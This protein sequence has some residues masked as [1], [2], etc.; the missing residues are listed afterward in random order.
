LN[1]RLTQPDFFLDEML[2]DLQFNPALTFPFSLDP[3]NRIPYYHQYSLNI[4]HQLTSDLLLEIGYAGS[5]GHKLGQRLNLNQGRV[6]P[7]GTVP[8][9]QRVRYPQ[10]SAILWTYN[11]GNSNY[12]EGTLR[13]EKRFSQGLSLLANYTFSKSIDSPYGRIRREHFQSERRP[14]GPSTFDATHRFVASYIYDLPFGFRRP[15]LSGS[16]G[17]VKHLVSGWQV[18]G[19]TTFM[20]GQPRNIGFIGR[21]PVVGPFSNVRA[22]RVGPGNC[23]QC[24]ENI[25]KNP[26]PGPYFRTEDFKLPADFTFGNAGRNILRAPGIN[27]WDLS[28]FKNNYI[29]E[30]VNVQFRAEFFNAFNHAQFTSFNATVGSPTYGRVTGAREGRDIQLALRV[31]F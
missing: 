21:A 2:P 8:L 11:G 19:I 27:N 16:T 18:N 4:Q 26:V 12:N 28:L 20:S 1:S 17:F 25:R 7:T 9:S 22:D 6:D 14:R 30:N 10:F 3:N 29:G 13:L 23:S 15:F 5:S 31:L 24:R